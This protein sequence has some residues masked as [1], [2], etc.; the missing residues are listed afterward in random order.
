MPASSHKLALALARRIGE[1]LPPPLGVRA[2]GGN[3]EVVRADGAALGGSAAAGIVDEADGRTLDERVETAG[4]AVLSGIQD[5]VAE[6][7]TVPWPARED[8]GMAMPGARAGAGR[9]RLWYGDSEEA[10]VVRLRPIEFEEF[11]QE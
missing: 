9:L 8:G 7:R 1:V 6:F 3:L 10:A 5:C 4:Q 2:V 11:N